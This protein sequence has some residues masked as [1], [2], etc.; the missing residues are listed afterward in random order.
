MSLEDTGTVKITK[1]PTKKSVATRCATC[2]VLIG[3]KTQT[4]MDTKATGV[5]YRLCAACLTKQE[6]KHIKITKKENIDL[7][8]Q[9]KAF[10][11]QLKQERFKK[12]KKEEEE[13]KPKVTITKT[14]M[15]KEKT[16]EV[17]KIVLK[18]KQIEDN[19]DD[20]I[21]KL[22]EELAKMKEE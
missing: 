22:K 9:K 8:S 16:T 7:M 17:E 20:E 13:N 19:K 6:D 11:L 1:Q 14:P 10:G 2:G 5:S 15:V 12:G 18:E 3:I 4:V 21:K